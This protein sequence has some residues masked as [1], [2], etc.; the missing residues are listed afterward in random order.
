MGL[1][2]GILKGV[3]NSILGPNPSDTASAYKRLQ[4]ELSSGYNQKKQAFEASPENKGKQYQMPDVVTRWGDQINAMITSGD[5]VLQ[6]N[7]LQQLGNY[8]Q[9]I[10]SVQ[11]GAE[12]PASIREYQYAQMQGYQ[13]SFQ[14]W[15]RAKAEAGRSSI[16]VN[17][18]K[19]DQPMS[20]SDAKQVVLPNGELAFGMTPNQAREAGGKIVLS[21]T[22][23][24]AGTAGDVLAAN[25]QLL[26]QNLNPSKNKVEAVTNELRT[27]P[28]VFGTVINAGMNLSG[29]PMSDKAAKFEL[30]KGNISQQQ[31]KLMSGA[32]ATESEMQQYRDK[33]PKFTDSPAVQRLKFQQ[34]TQFADSVIQRNSQAGIKPSSHKPASAEWS[35]EDLARGY[36]VVK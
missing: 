1:L 18:A 21:D 2:D 14:D 23:H 33:L 6:Q 25:Q 15:L 20:V 16:N 30:A 4:D 28:N 9:R 31:L 29:I 19:Q 8:Q 12:A 13:G 5:P 36:R 3:E 35:K 11:H 10:T 27:M 26:E 22:Q 34:A 24:Q 17:I 32:S 7:A